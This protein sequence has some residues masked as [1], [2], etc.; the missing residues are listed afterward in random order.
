MLFDIVYCDLSV[1]YIRC[2]F[3]CNMAIQPGGSVMRVSGVNA[4]GR[5]GERSGERAGVREWKGGKDAIESR[6]FGQWSLFQISSLMTYQLFS[7]KT[8]RVAVGLRGRRRCYD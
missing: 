8:E 6:T 3:I 7:L 2:L 4:G 1:V 5:Q